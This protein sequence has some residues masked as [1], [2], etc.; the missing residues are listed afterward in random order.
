M[1]DSPRSTP[2]PAFDFDTWAELARTDPDAFEARRKAAIERTIERAQPHQRERLRRLQWKVDRIRDLSDHPLGA[3]V[4]ISDL[5][6]RSVTGPG[7]LQQALGLL[8]T[9]APAVARSAACVLPFKAH[10]HR[11]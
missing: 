4:R 3:C 7:G 2:E 8:G 1:S 9:G 10:K 6:W 11:H 5:M